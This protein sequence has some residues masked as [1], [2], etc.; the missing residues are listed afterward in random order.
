VG[1]AFAALAGLVSG[2]IAV[3]LMRRMAAR[4]PRDDPNSRSLHV[5][6][7]PRAGGYAIW[8][9]FVPVALLSPPPFALPGLAGWLPAWLAVAL[10]SA[11]DDARGVRPAARLAVH[12]VA[13]LACAYA[14][15]RGADGGA[16][17]LPDGAP[18]W[19]AVLGM[20]LAIAWMANLYNFMDGSDG[21]AATMALAGFGAYAAAAR[22]A[23]ADGAAFAALAASALAFLAVNRPRATM[24]L[25][26]VGSVPIGFLAA[27]FGLSGILT[28]L[29]PA[30]F[31]ML[32]FLPFAA[33]ATVTLARRAVRGDN[34]VQ[35]HRD[36]Y[37]QRLNRMGAGHAGTL[38]AYALA[39][40][41]CAAAALY[42][43]MRA[44]AAG[45]AALGI[46][47]VVC[48]I[49]FGAIDHRWR[50]RTEASQ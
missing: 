10:V 29:W 25:G 47:C 16:G 39:M 13:A 26:D 48:F 14:L 27:A 4:L 46:A 24:F 7:I 45:T 43:L 21:L 11:A 2:G 50:R 8:A 12:G 18:A 37:Y 15:W 32:V 28:G 17:T 49:L 30:W 3:A 40:A 23:G 1:L 33:D 41:A 31:P 34:L 22:H 38:A 6:P 35:A 9:G 19:A 44:P 42:C 36:H 20:A 5:A